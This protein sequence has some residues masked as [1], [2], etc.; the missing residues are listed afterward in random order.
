MT[1]KRSPLSPEQLESI[2]RTIADTS[3]GL[4]GTEI[5]KIL[6]DSGIPDVDPTNTK[7]KRLYNAF[8]SWQNQYACS[9]NI[10]NFLKS[11]L[12]PI[13]YIGREDVFEARRHEVN[14]RLSFIGSEISNKGTLR[15]VNKSQTISE[16]EQRASHFKYKLKVRDAHSE[17]FKY[18]E[19]EIMDENYFHTVFESVKS[20]ADRLRI[21]TNL[22]ADGNALAE[23]A[24]SLKNPLIKV[25][26]LRDEND[27]SEHVGLMN[28]IKGLF[29]L[30]RNPTAHIPKIR[31]TIHEDEALDILT[32]V[33]LVHKK[34]DKAVGV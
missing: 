22:Y 1:V 29:G 33:S 9:N 32:A 30:I 18:C 2:C 12:S 10:L 7:W 20:I 21:L 11:A 19:T 15:E 34:L 31:F 5:G 25:N 8:V 26:S 23:V 4:T 24:F 13:K 28:M 3:D 14:K 16:A 17:I 6:L 27:R